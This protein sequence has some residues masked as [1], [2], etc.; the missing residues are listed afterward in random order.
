MEGKN[1]RAEVEALAAEKGLPLTETQIM[2]V[3]G[4]VSAIRK[5]AARLRDGL[6]RNDEPAFGFRHP[7]LGGTEE[8]D[9]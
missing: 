7:V 4:S 8:H 6:H 2:Q 9:R 1:I 3:V 5:S